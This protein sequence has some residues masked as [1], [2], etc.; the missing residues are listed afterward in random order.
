[1][2]RWRVSRYVIF[3][4]MWTPRRRRMPLDREPGSGDPLAELTR[5]ARAGETRAIH[6]LLVAIAPAVLRVARQVLGPAHPEVQ[7]V[8]QEAACGVLRGLERFRG[9][10]TLM[11]FACRTAVLASMNVRRRDVS[12]SRKAR[13]LS[14]LLGEGASSPS[15]ERLLLGQRAAAALRELLGLLPEAQAEVLALHH[16]VGLTA[17]EIASATSTPVETVR[18]R[19]RLGR[20]ALRQRVL[21]DEEL[22]EVMGVSDGHA[23]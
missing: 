12:Q 4:L 11:H 16:V 15:P 2:T 17:A 14:E 5:R 20:Q 13:G 23:R 21:G 1:V 19:L 18:S 9:E 7:D 6:E 8:A 3:T 22:A 10:C